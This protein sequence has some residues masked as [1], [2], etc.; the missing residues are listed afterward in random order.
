MNKKYAGC[1]LNEIIVGEPLPTTLYLFINSKF[2][3]YRTPGDIIDRNTYIRLELK[4][5]KNLYIKQEDLEKFKLW[6]KKHTPELPG[7][8]PETQDFQESRQA[9]QRKMLDIFQSNHPD[10]AITQAMG[11]SKKLVFEVIKFPYTAHNLTLLQLYSR[12]AVD[13]SVNVSVLSVYIAMQMGYSHAV[14]LQHIGAGGLLHDVGKSK[15]LIKDEDTEEIVR[16]KMIEHPML[17]A[18]LLEGQEKIPN[19]VRTIVS[20]HH[21]CFDGS[22]YPNRLR[23]NAIYD[24]TRIVSIANVFDDLMGEVRGTIYERQKEAIELLDT[25]YYNLFD[26]EK[27]DK[28]IKILKKGF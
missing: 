24:L 26:P 25:N 14:T 11:A 19:E 12:G 7:L 20:Q 22:G 18:A 16:D 10:R 9:I 13:H 4:K 1:D 3:T 6:S 5:V 15:V 8:P 23:G 2:I 27:L 17:G 28:S 21:E